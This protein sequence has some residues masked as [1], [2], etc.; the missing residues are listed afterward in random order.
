[1]NGVD[2]TGTEIDWRTNA[3]P[4]IITEDMAGYYNLVFYWRNS[5]TSSKHPNPSAVIDNVR[6]EKAD[7]P[8]PVDL[9]RTVLGDTTLTVA[10]KSL[11]ESITAWNVKVLETEWGVDSVGVAPDSVVVGTY[12]V[13][14]ALEY[15]ISGLLPDTEYYIYVQGA[16]GG[17]WARVDARTIC[18]PVEVGYE[19]T[20]DEGGGYPTVSSETYLAPD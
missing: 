20:F 14:N 7:C 13:E 11:S 19:W 15:T 16:C 9:E 12:L 10:W 18:T 5:S 1:M 17:N 4:V 6:I 8:V 3:V 2:T